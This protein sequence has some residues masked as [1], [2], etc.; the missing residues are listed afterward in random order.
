VWLLGLPVWGPIL[1]HW[2]T[3]RAVYPRTKSLAILVV[4]TTVVV[5]AILGQ[6]SPP[7]LM[8]LLPLAAIGLIVIWRLPVIVLGDSTAAARHRFSGPNDP[9]LIGRGSAG[10][11]PDANHFRN[12]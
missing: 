12:S 1:R 3:H 4:A 7:L 2:E 10:H 8:V 9:V 5:S 6:F 11:H